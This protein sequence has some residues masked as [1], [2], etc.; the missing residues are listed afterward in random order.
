MD[1][2][3]EQT[4]AMIFANLAGVSVDIRN[5]LGGIDEDETPRLYDALV[6]MN[7]SIQTFKDQ[8]TRELGA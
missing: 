8:V 2:K 3:Q 5:L 1:R 6:S 4:F 7:N